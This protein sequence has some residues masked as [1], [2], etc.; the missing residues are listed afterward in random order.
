MQVGS[1]LQ[2]IMPSMVQG[3]RASDHFDI[4]APFMCPHSK[5]TFK[6]ITSCE[7][8]CFVLKG[9]SRKLELKGQFVRTRWVRQ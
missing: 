8:L 9:R 3:S 4:I 6:E 7:D 2:R 5:W 1:V